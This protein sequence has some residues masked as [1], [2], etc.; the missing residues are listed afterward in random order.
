MFDFLAR[1][2]I[3]SMKKICFLARKTKKTKK[4]FFQT[5]EPAQG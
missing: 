4:Q 2:Q 1:K 5:M 3:V